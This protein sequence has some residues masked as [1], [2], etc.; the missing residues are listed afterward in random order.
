MK[1]KS[2]TI[3]D[4][5]RL[6]GLGTSTVSAYFSG[7]GYLSEKSRKRIAKVVER[8]SYRVNVSAS[9][10]R[11]KSNRQI[12][13]LIPP[14]EHNPTYTRHFFLGEKFSAALEEV[15]ALGY[16]LLLLRIP[17]ASD[18]EF[19]RLIRTHHFSAALFMESI[20]ES[21]AQILARFKIPFVFS[22]FNTPYS[23]PS[24]RYEF[25]VGGKN[26]V[27]T[28]HPEVFQKVIAFAKG[29][30]YEGFAYW[31]FR[32]TMEGVDK[33][34]QGE[35]QKNG[36]KNL[37][38]PLRDFYQGRI[39]KEELALLFRET[40]TLAYIEMPG[41]AVRFHSLFV[42][43]KEKLAGLIALDNPPDFRFLEPQI[44]YVFSNPN[45]IGRESVRYLIDR[46]ATPSADTESKLISST[47]EE[48]GTT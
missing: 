35:L 7:K 11:T 15:F 34:A 13:M 9:L 24:V 41:D 1:K 6:S 40:K 26:G 22:N 31:D 27:V 36:L 28:N 45:E 18:P 43:G 32:G 44:S 46:M 8:T 20:P 21:Y 23:D 47:I 14:P 2:M 3:R 42:A 37:T 39:S 48:R 10:L 4:I 17:L 33:L 16:E 19:D 29:K 30:N 5:S 12:A 38:D 25:R